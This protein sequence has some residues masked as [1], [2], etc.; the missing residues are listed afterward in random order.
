MTSNSE[1][2]KTKKVEDRKTLFNY[3]L[4]FVAIRLFVNII[5]TG[6]SDIYAW[7]DFAER[8][9]EVGVVKYYSEN[10]L[11]NHPPLMG[12]YTYGVLQLSQLLDIRFNDVFNIPMMIADAIILINIYYLSGKD[13]KKVFLWVIN[14]IS[15]L[16][17]S[18]HGNSDILVLALVTYSVYFI[19]KNRLFT[20]GLMYG[21]AINVKIIPIILFPLF[22]F[23][24]TGLNISLRHKNLK[25]LNYNFL[26]GFLIVLTPFL[27]PLTGNTSDF[28]SNVIGYNS[29]P[30]PWGILFLFNGFNHLD[31]FENIDN[32][33][34]NYGKYLLL[35]TIT[36]LS[37][38]NFQKKEPLIKEVLMVFLLFLAIGPGFGVQYLVYPLPFIIIF[39]KKKACYYSLLATIAMIAVYAYFN[40]QLLP[41]LSLHDSR[42]PFYMGT[43]LF[44]VWCCILYLLVRILRGKIANHN[45]NCQLTSL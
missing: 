23:Y 10:P 33:Y 30:E 43:Y 2:S 27:W 1:L 39:D 14:P 12:L 24:S 25:N 3:L 6:S 41:I 44:P 21:L 45:N 29:S 15:I 18:Y 16:I 31:V 37:C 11:F 38:R 26:I 42:L 9:S 22:F 13:K 20:S 7:Q 32:Y 40:V 34:F 4:L 36:I 35:T 19:T 17:S 8:I 5:S 28:L